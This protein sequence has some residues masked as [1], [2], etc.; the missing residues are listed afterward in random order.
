MA[1]YAFIHIPKNAGTSI[2]RVLKNVP[3]IDFF[4]HGVLK[5]RIKDHKKIYILRDPVDRFTSAFFYL[6]RFGHN[7]ENDFFKNPDE[8]LQAIGDNDPR[9]NKFMKIHKGNHHVYGQPIPTDWVFH[10]QSAWIFDPWRIILFHKLEEEI[11][12]LNETI[13]VDIKINHHNASRRI[14]FEYSN[15]SIE[16]LQT[17]YTEDFEIY[18]KYTR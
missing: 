9:A 10:P 3:E 11:V 7:R 8:L 5:P 1:E 18:G 6:K 16:L 14:N 4:G 17:I 15:D 2:E 13:G 12:S